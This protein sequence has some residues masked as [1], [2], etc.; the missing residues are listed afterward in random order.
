VLTPIVERARG[1]L[2]AAGGSPFR[3]R[4]NDEDGLFERYDCPAD[5]VGDC[6][7]A[8]EEDS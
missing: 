6:V 5:G 7:F 1:R 4:W 3:V 2:A 8:G